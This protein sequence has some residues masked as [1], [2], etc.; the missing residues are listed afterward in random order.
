MPLYGPSTATATVAANTNMVS[1]SGMDISSNIVAQGMTISFGARDRQ[2]GDAW[3]INTVTPNGTSGGT[4]TLAGSVAG[5]YTNAPFLIDTRGFLGTDSSYAAAVSLKLLATFNNL[6]GA[7]TN[8]F[9][10]SRQLVLDKVAS[11]AIGRV[12]FAIAGRAWGD[13]AQRSLTYTPT[14]GQMTSIETLAVRAFPDGTTPTDALLIDLTSGTGDLRKTVAV[15]ASA[16]TVDLS[17]A[18]AGKVTITGTATISSFGPGKNLERLGDFNNSGGVLKHSASLVLT[19][20]A[21]IAIQAG[22]FFHATSDGA[23]NWRV[24]YQRA[25]G[26]ALVP[27]SPAESG[28]QPALGFTPV[29]QG[30]GVSQGTNKI[31]VGYDNTGGYPRMTVDAT[32][33]GQIWCAVQGALSLGASSAYCKFPN[34]L[35]IQA[36]RGVSGSTGDQTVSFPLAF[37]NACVCVL[38]GPNF[39]TNSTYFYAASADGW[40]SST[41]NIRCR[42]IFN[43]SI[44]AQSNLPFIYLA[45]GY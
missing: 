36:A 1:I 45:V 21:D 35:I 44:T 38:A 3:V 30:G 11:T 19:G 16:A 15:M 10:G 28:A 24:R 29:Q 22:D 13:I 39:E 37:P 2:T 14:G 7:A 33:M 6:L 41:V 12:A 18:P 43:N 9:A 27:A 17:S 20:G 40:T 31:L 26:K 23:G 8:L 32:D 5:G 25:S 4:L 42:T 34:G